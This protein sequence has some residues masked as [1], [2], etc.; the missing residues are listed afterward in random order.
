MPRRSANIVAGASL[1]LCVAVGAA[2]VRSLN[3]QDRWFFSPTTPASTTLASTDIGEPARVIPVVAQRILCCSEGRI[4]I[5]RRISGEPHFF[6]TGYWS[7]GVDLLRPPVPTQDDNHRQLLGFEYYR[8][9]ARYGRVGLSGLGSIVH[10]GETSIAVPLWFVFV[11]TAVLPA[12]SIT[13]G[14]RRWRRSRVPGLCS[15]CGY[16]LRAS[17]ERC[18]ECGAAAPQPGMSTQAP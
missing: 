4:R 2:W 3:V 7:A 9:P 15:A 18:P 10:I 17:P 12:V 13:R 14:V 16:D 11:I 5:I 1:L 8:R 6:L